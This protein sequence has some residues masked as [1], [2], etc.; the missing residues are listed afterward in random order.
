MAYG[1]VKKRGKYFH[2]Y[3]HDNQG[4][5]HRKSTG[6]K[7][8][9][10]AEYRLREFEQLSNT[11]EENPKEKTSFEQAWTL[12]QQESH[13]RLK[14]VTLA[15]YKEK[16][17]L[18]ATW[19]VETDKTFY[20]QDIT[21]AKLNA[22]ITGRNQQDKVSNHTIVKELSALK[23]VLRALKFHGL[24][25]GSLADLVPTIP[26]NYN[27]KKDHLTIQE[28]NKLL[29]YLPKE[30]RSHVAFMLATGARKSEAANARLEDI[31]MLQGIHYV[32]IRGTK[33]KG[34]EA[35]IPVILP[36]LK[37]KLVFSL[38][39]WPKKEKPTEP[40]FR[41]DLSINRDLA[42]AAKKAGI[43]R[44]SPNTLR[45]TTAQWYLDAG[46]PLDQVSSI[47]RHASTAM[48]YRVYGK[49]TPSSLA[50]RLELSLGLKKQC[51]THV[52]TP[53]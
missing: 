41:L 19:F 22:Y 50:D 10:R 53:V 6:E 29:E 28:A 17:E 40:L 11:P 38:E 4:Q 49:P 42:R 13:L 47:L 51:D 12:F 36:V 37:E 30:R 31:T 9:K 2:A 39:N 33:T 15:F 48:V 35:T 18:L 34:S 21:R 45:H 1:H 14:P 3:W 16:F 26:S 8:R 46:V 52:P 24:W 25:E 23:V 20:L 27:P 32:R 44:V 43:P 5:R 7:D